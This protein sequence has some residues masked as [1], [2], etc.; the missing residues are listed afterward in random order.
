M[1]NGTETD[2]NT[3]CPSCG[4]S[5]VVSLTVDSWA[6]PLHEL[7]VMPCR[8]CEM[9]HARCD[10]RRYLRAAPCCRNCSHPEPDQETTR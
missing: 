4:A 8:Y 10:G 5:L 7:T 1:S 3:Y 9:S 6:P 2:A